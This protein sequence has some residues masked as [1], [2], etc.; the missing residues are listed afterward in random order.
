MVFTVKLIRFLIYTLVVLLLCSCVLFAFLQTKWAKDQIR[1]KITAYL[2]EFGTEARIGPLTG[3]LPF[4]WEIPEA[5]FCL[6]NGDSAQLSDL[7]LRIAI[8][9]LLRGKIVINYLNIEHLVYPSSAQAPPIEISKKRLREQIEG[10]SLPCQI[11]IHRFKIEL[12]EIN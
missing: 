12:L 4:S 5:D 7:K 11:D 1:T 6:N 9:P 3:R 10:L 8:L 2:N